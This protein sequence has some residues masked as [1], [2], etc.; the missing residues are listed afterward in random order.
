MIKWFRSQINV[1]KEECPD[2]EFHFDLE[3]AAS[4]RSKC[5]HCKNTIAK[6]THRFGLVQDYMEEAI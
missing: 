2:T 5:K 6:D 1:N 4:G 3:T